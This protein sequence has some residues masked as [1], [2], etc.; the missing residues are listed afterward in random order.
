MT[1]S[2]VQAYMAQKKQEYKKRHHAVLYTTGPCQP[3]TD[4]EYVKIKTGM[5]SSYGAS[6]KKHSN[7][8]LWN[9]HHDYSHLKTD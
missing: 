2:D 7:T 6:G 9:H 4:E 8:K 1:K 5:K 3:F